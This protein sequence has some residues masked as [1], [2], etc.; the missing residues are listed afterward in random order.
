M[1]MVLQCQC[2]S[3]ALLPPVRISPRLYSREETEGER[4]IEVAL[5]FVDETHGMCDIS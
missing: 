3:G 4:F 5:L 1:G 2:K